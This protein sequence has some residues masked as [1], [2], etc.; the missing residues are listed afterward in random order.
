MVCDCLETV[1]DEKIMFAMT[2]AFLNCSGLTDHDHGYRE[3]SSLAAVAENS[4]I[5]QHRQRDKGCDRA[6]ATG[7]KRSGD[8]S[9]LTLTAD[10]IIGAIRRTVLP[11]LLGP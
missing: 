3:R 10:L 8:P 5:I 2:A 4:R 11:T 1:S 9:S 6:P 7:T